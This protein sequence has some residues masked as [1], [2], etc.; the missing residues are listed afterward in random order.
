MPLP[1]EDYAVIG[2]TQSAALVGRDGSIDWLCWP[3]FDSA[4]CLAALLGEARHGRWLIAPAGNVRQVQRRYRG[5][6]LVLETEF[7][8]D[9]GA[10]RLLDFMPPRDQEPNIVRVV[11][12]VRGQV[13]LRME[14]RVRFDYGQ[15][16]PWVREDDEGTTYLAGP[17]AVTLRSPVAT[18]QEDQATVAEFTVGPGERLPMVLTWYPS[19]Q[20]APAPVDPLLALDETAAYWQEWA[21]R[22]TYQGEWRDAVLR[23]LMVLKALTYGPTGGMVA[24]ATTSLPE[25]LGGVRNWDY[26]YCWLRDAVLTLNAL[27]TCGYDAEASAFQGWLLRAIAGD[28][29]QLQIMYGLAGERRLQE[30]T[31]D[32]LPG[33]E[34][35][36]PVRVGNAA[37]GQFQL[38]VYGEVLG[39]GYLARTRGWE[40]DPEGWPIQRTVLDHLASVWDQPDEGIWEVRGPRRHFT[41]SK[42]MAWFA[43][44]C[45][46][47]AAEEF[48]LPGPVER[49]REIAN[50]IHD[51]VCERGYDAE[52]GTFTQFYGSRTLDASLLA[53]PL[54]GFLPATDPRVEGTVAA[55][56]R[57]LMADGFL[58]RYPTEDGGSVDGLPPGEGAFLACTFWLVN[59]YALM[60]RTDEARALFE[61][62]LTLR[63]DLG[64]LSEEYD[65]KARRLVGN[66]PQAFSHLALI[67]AAAQLVAQ[68]ARERVD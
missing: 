54:L 65:P 33:Y 67:N 56:E 47:K 58:L 31:L 4:A 29:A 13:P 49:W 35:A 66:F 37:A 46:A 17:E 62:L 24:A 16:V 11:E 1:I 40:P 6:T 27:N 21:A 23:S 50:Q 18:G 14:L 8:T 48:G 34:G 2:D 28:P 19:W 25:Q 63:N 64:L 7:E 53:I 5:D 26:R 30:Y 60:G 51:Q 32:W 39:A 44:T 52:R 36:A 43:F 22:C 68:T 45:A 57:E 38:D 20:S 15:T 10:V 61:R 55:I 42:V 59:V 41:H 3:R 12:G 9:A